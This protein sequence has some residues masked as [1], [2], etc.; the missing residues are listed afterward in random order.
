MGKEYF[1]MWNSYLKSVEP[2]NDSE[3]GRLF[4][5]L[6]EYSNTGK[7]PD[8]R[9]NERFLFPMMKENL[10]RDKESY[11]RIVERNSK[12]GENGGRPKNPKKNPVG[13]QETQKT[14]TNPKAQEKEKDKDK[15]EDKEK[16]KIPPKSPQGEKTP[17]DALEGREIPEPIKA[18]LRKWFQYKKERREAYKPTGLQSFLST[19][20]K[21]CA[22]YGVEDIASL[23]EESMS[24]GWR[25]IIWERL[26]GKEKPKEKPRELPPDLIEAKR[27]HEEAMKRLQAG[28]G[29][30]EDLVP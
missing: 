22:M 8:L 3:R 9:G 25:G 29:S 5:A 30:W 2:L 15:E 17:D 24:N 10:D 27:K 21:K 4:T 1:K 18:E 28:E 6:L 13:F 14:Q 7:V 19:V 23:I 16:D 26:S 20:E 11:G 12:N